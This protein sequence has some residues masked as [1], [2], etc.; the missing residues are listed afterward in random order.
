ME[1]TLEAAIGRLFGGTPPAPA[2]ETEQVRRGDLPDARPASVTTPVPNGDAV[3][4][5]TL[6]LE[7]RG[8]YDAAI[9][10]QRAGDWSR[11][12]DELR[13]LGEVLER[14]RK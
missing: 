5:D 11:Y 10:A 4:L 14:M 8:H 2:P 3:A 12:G 9:A 13:R 7:A 6:A 1:P